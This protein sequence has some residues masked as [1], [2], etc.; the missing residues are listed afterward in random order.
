VIISCS[1]DLAEC[2]GARCGRARSYCLQHI[3]TAGIRAVPDRCLQVQLLLPHLAKSKSPGRVVVVGS[4]LSDS[5]PKW[6]TDPAAVH[7]FALQQ[8]QQQQQQQQVTPMQWYAAT[9]L[10]NLWF[11]KQLARE[12]SSSRV[13]GRVAV[14]AVAPGFIP[15]TGESCAASRCAGVMPHL[16]EQLRLPSNP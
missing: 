4:K 16:G 9:K 11:M 6:L 10:C 8:Q 1:G 13:A 2:A 7:G 12:V 3:A 15:S 14:T 5:V